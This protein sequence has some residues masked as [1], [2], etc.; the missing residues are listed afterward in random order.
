MPTHA[1]FPI[2]VAP[3]PDAASPLSD[4]S[5]ARVVA[6]LAALVAPP[7]PAVPSLSR[8]D[9]GVT[10]HRI[11]IMTASLARDGDVIEPLGMDVAN[12]LTNPI[13][14]WAHDASGRTPA[15]GLP[16]GRTLA[17]NRHADG[18]DATFEFLPDD[19]FAQ[20]VQ[21]AWQR[22]FLRTASIGW[23]SKRS[24]PLPNGRGLRHTQT[25]LLEWSLVPLPADPGA[26]RELWLAGLRSLGFSDLLGEANSLLPRTGEGRGESDYARGV[27]RHPPLPTLVAELADACDYL[28]TRLGGHPLRSS[29]LRRDLSRISDQLAH[30]LGNHA[31][32]DHPVTTSSA[33]RWRPTGNDTAVAMDHACLL[34][35]AAELRSLA[36]HL[37]A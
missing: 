6:S 25:Q 21:N 16:I 7:H 34:T 23:E 37:Q 5:P 9:A 19:P 28:H 15:A 26:S 20:R 11:R 22:G 27:I 35:A 12:Y 3:S 17:L 13:V 4:L 1:C 30:A 33:P 10:R 24:I 32:S 2:L 18:I 36:Q 29:D 14:L 8:A 31:L